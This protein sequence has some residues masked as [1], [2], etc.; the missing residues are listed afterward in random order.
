MWSK[1]EGAWV[2]A[3][4]VAAPKEEEQVRSLAVAAGSR[5]LNR[6]AP[7]RCAGLTR[8]AAP[9]P[10]RGVYGRPQTTDAENASPAEQNAAPTS[11][12]D[13]MASKAEPA[14]P[15]EAASAQ[16]AEQPSCLPGSSSTSA[17]VFANGDNQNCGN[18]ITDRS[19]TRVR[20]PPGGHST[21]SFY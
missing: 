21:I 11:L 7:L 16:A 2:P 6:D 12:A 10:A 8:N 3:K 18:F 9:P 14:A 5:C 4:I 1:K 19:T 13:V 20:A 15:A 17:N